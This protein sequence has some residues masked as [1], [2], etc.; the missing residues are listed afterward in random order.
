MSFGFERTFIISGHDRLQPSKQNKDQARKCLT[1]QTA[2]RAGP[3]APAYWRAGSA[4]PGAAGAI[5]RKKPK[6]VLGY[7]KLLL[8]YAENGLF[9]AEYSAVAPVMP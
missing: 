7:R 9:L 8:G 4:M 2:E 5:S 1:A 6:L 3:R